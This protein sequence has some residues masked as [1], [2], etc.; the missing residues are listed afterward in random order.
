M[1]VLQVENTVLSLTKASFEV[2][3]LKDS[4]PDRRRSCGVS[5]GRSDFFG[6]S[7]RLRLIQESVV[8]RPR[9][10]RGKASSSATWNLGRRMSIK[11]TQSN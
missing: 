8:V 10:S 9:R 2:N 6:T 5:G 4:I 3:V 1:A 7:E 11:D